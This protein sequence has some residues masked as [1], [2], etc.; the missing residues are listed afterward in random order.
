MKTRKIIL[1]I[2]P[3][4]AFDLAYAME[5]YITMCINEAKTVNMFLYEDFKSECA[6]LQHFVNEGFNLYVHTQSI[7]DYEKPYRD[8]DEWYKAL[9]KKRKKELSTSASVK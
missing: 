9:V 6:I 2:T 3:D 8:V 7:K 1:E 5:N 4:E